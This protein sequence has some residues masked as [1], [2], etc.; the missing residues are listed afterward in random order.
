MGFFKH[1]FALETAREV[2]F[3]EPEYPIIMKPINPR[4][5]RFLKM[6]S[7]LYDAEKYDGEGDFETANE[8]LKLLSKEAN[9][10]S[11]QHDNQ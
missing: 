7:L 5:K 10:Q 8:L 3:P 6:K 1:F 4:K 2:G 9:S 11:I